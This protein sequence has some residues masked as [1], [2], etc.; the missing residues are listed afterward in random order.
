MDISLAREIRDLVNIID[1][2]DKN[3]K[4]LNGGYKDEFELY[5]NGIKKTD[6]TLNDIDTLINKYKEE[7]REAEEKLKNIKNGGGR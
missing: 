2:V 5:Q 3:L 6:L 4:I 1:K 7:K